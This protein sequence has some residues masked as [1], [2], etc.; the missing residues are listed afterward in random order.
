MGAATTN[1][2]MTPE[3]EMLRRRQSGSGLDARFR[4]SFRTPSGAVQ[5]EDVSMSPAAVM[6]R[7][8]ARDGLDMRGYEQQADSLTDVAVRDLETGRVRR[9]RQGSNK[10]ALYDP[11]VDIL[12]GV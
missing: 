1:S 9:A 6:R 8:A 7:L 12:G 2:P 11:S 10:A 3:Q 5:V 4:D